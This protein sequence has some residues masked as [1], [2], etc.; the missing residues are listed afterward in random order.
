M[1]FRPFLPLLCLIVFLLPGAARSQQDGDEKESPRI[2]SYQL[3]SDDSRL[4]DELDHDLMSQL[5]FSRATGEA[6]ESLRFVLRI[7]S[8]LSLESFRI[9]GPEDGVRYRIEGGGLGAVRTGLQEVAE[10]I[11]DGRE[12]PEKKVSSPPF[13]RRVLRVQPPRLGAEPTGF[14]DRTVLFAQRSRFNTLAVIVPLSADKAG[15]AALSAYETSCARAGLSFVVLFTIGDEKVQDLESS[16]LLLTAGL[17]SKNLGV[18]LTSGDDG[19]SCAPLLSAAGN[20]VPDGS[21]IWIEGWRGSRGDLD[22]VLVSLDGEEIR[23]VIS[24]PYNGDFLLSSEKS[25]FVDPSFLSSDGSLIPDDRIEVVFRLENSDTRVLPW[26]EPNYARAVTSRLVASGASGAVFGA[27]RPDF[28]GTPV[29]TTTD[30]PESWKDLF[31]FERRWVVYRTWGRLL[32]DPSSSNDFLEGEFVARFGLT[33]GPLFLSS[34]IR[35]SRFYPWIHGFHASPT[36]ASWYPEGVVSPSGGSSGVE[37]GWVDAAPYRGI[38]EFMLHA[39]ADPDVL[40]PIAYAALLLEKLGRP[41]NE[42]KRRSG[43]LPAFDELSGKRTPIAVFKEITRESGEARNI[44]DPIVHDLK[45]PRSEENQAFAKDV[46]CLS[47]LGLHYGA[48]IRGATE[49]ACALSGIEGSGMYKKKAD[50]FSHQSVAWYKYLT[51][52]SKERFAPFDIEGLPDFS[53]DRFMMDVVAEENG[54]KKTVVVDRAGFDL[55]AG[56][57]GASVPGVGTDYT[58]VPGLLNLNWPGLMAKSRR[59]K[60]GDEGLIEAEQMTGRWSE[61]EDENASGSIFRRSLS[62]NQGMPAPALLHRIEAQDGLLRVFVRARRVLEDNPGD[63]GKLRVRLWGGLLDLFPRELQFAPSTSE[64]EWVV[65][66]EKPLPVKAGHYVLEIVQ[67]GGSGFDVDAVFL[68]G[69]SNGVPPK[70][71]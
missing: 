7:D 11:R 19:A 6:K 9:A 51:W 30:N 54:M 53:W 13:S 3:E 23:L 47:N 71:K 24:I 60:N 31:N 50:V 65:T 39:P 17:K 59:L 2:L 5:G 70:S 8:S 49:L 57:A 56:F 12:L 55:C 63:P 14:V 43:R 48:K 32:H 20:A 1:F 21:E 46:L 45:T 10:C 26:C 64:F 34:L 58:L 67:E 61:H 62:G 38:F 41:E 28:S 16:V 18:Y 52:E 29:H 27:T 35:A 66:R 42:K 37:S 15:A 22:P 69:D 68:T 44:V 36:V 33:D 40:S 25:R 4:A